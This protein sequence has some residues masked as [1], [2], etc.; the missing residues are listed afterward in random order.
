MSSG[1][2]FDTSRIWR[3]ARRCVPIAVIWLVLAGAG[4]E[5]LVVGAIIVPL[6]TWLSLYLLPGG[7][8]Q[9]GPLAALIPRFVWQSLIGGIDVARCAFHPH[10]P[11][12]PGRLRI[13][14]DLPEGGRVALGGELSLMPGTLAA[15]C[16]GDHLLVHVL[17][18]DHDIGSAV[19][20][21]ERRVRGTIDRAKAR[22]NRP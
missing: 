20:E 12:K 5:A 6:A 8:V 7:A 19:R 11:I 10:L 21:E 9:F 16:D 18:L 17:D 22:E 3:A 2:T 1:L 14:V 13:A 4:G 15:G